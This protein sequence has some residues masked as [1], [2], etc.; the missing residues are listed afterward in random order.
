MSVTLYPSAVRFNDN[1][2]YRSVAA[3]ADLNSP[4]LIGTPT[5]PTAE[6]G[7]NTT[8]IATTAFVYTAVS[9]KSDK[10]I[11]FSIT[12]PYANW[13]GNDPYTQTVTVTG[14]TANSKV[15]LQPDDAQIVQLI[16]DGVKSLRIDNNNGT[17]VAHAIG[18][19]PST[20]LTLQATRVEV[21]T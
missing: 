2:T 13:S 20:T 16:A 5:A 8:Q 18:A 11:V 9:G 19:A 15:S 21:T 7:T 12:I 6:P 4:S 17:F 3:F 10:Q 14:G 1:G